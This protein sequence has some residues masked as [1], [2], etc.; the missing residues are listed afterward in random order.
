MNRVLG[1]AALGTTF[2]AAADGKLLRWS[3]DDNVRRWTPARETL[4][5]LPL[6]NQGP[7]PTEPPRLAQRQLE[8]KSKDRNTCAYVNGDAG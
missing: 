5:V 3:P 1:L 7:Q 8:K 6:L 4:G 2:A